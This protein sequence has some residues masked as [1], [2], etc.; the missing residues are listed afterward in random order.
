MKPYN[1]ARI[2]Y[3][4]EVIVTGDGISFRGLSGQRHF[5]SYNPGLQEPEKIILCRTTS[6][7]S[8]QSSVYLGLFPPYKID[9][10]TYE[11]LNRALDDMEAHHDDTID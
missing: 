2:D 1:P 4:H 9:A 11:L 8:V 3:G 6:T 5:L 10:L 7:Y